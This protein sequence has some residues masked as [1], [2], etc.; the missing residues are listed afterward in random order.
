MT[1]GV[2]R[3]L[4]RTL[5]LLVCILWRRGRVS[6]RNRLSLAFGS[7]PPVNERDVFT[8]LGS[9]LADTVALFDRSVRASNLMPLSQPGKKVLEQALSRKQGAI[10]VTAHL[11]PIDIMAAS[12]AETLCGSHEVATLARESYDRRFTALYDELRLPR[13]V[14]TLY[15]GRR[16]TTRS[17]VRALRDGKL[18]GFPV[19]IVGRGMRGCLVPFL[20][21]RSLMAMG[22]LS[23]A[24]RMRVP[25]VIGTPTATERGFEIT[26][27]P[28]DAIMCGEMS[29]ERAIEVMASVLDRRIMALPAHYAWMHDG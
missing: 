11:G 12:I 15:R 17:V 24:R 26:V 1:S 18:V 22:P 23:L 19:D 25:I 10:Y 27:E 16:G 21:G 4:G 13:G 7:K 8:A 5:G 6:T 14:Q 20:G 29:N 9:D 3:S 28:F 2:R